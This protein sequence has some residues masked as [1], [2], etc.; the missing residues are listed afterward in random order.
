MWGFTTQRRI[1]LDH[2]GAM[3]VIPS[4]QMAFEKSSRAYGNPGAFHSEAQ[5]ASV[6]LREARA[7]IAHQLGSKAREIIF[8]SGGTEGNNL[9]LLGWAQAQ[10]TK[11]IHIVVSAIE[12][13]SILEVAVT[14]SA[15]GFSVSYVEPDANG[16][17]SAEVVKE[18]M[19]PNTAFVSIGWANGETGVVQPLS[20]IAQVIRAHEKEHHSSVTFHSDLGQ[21]PLYLSPQVHSLGVD[22]ATL[23]GGKLGSP[24]GV[25][26]LFVKEGVVLSPIMHGGSQESGMRPGTENVGLACGF[27]A[28]L[29]DVSL[30]RVEE[31]ER[32][33]GLREHLIRSIGSF[34]GVVVNGTSTHQ[35]PHL[36]NISIPHVDNEYITLALDRAGFAV[37]TKSA[38]KEGEKASHVILAMTN[39]TDSWRASSALRISMGRGTTLRGIDSFLSALSKVISAYRLHSKKEH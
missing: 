29:E 15:R 2:A 38:C 24:R 5:E 28:A 26:V 30:V 16:R 19:L 17:I 11:N 34:D 1:Y 33:A 35:L 9:A 14:L 37:A 6:L 12:H 3:P 13:P 21:A 8:T 4:A 36:I 27:A 10:R 25:G 31:T 23:D 7:Q 22:L 20:A 18:Q 32:M 39:E